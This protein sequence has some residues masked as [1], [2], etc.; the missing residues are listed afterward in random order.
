M[1]T[2]CPNA[3]TTPAI[4]AETVSR[5]AE[6]ALGDELELVQH[7]AEIEFATLPKS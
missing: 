3:R 6:W 4:S 7:A 2:P 5:V 1:I